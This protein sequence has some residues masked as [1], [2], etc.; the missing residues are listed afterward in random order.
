MLPVNASAPILVQYTNEGGIQN[1]LDILPSITEEAFFESNPEA[2]RA[3]AMHTMCFEGDAEG[4]M[5]L[6]RDASEEG[7]NVEDLIRFQDPLEDLKSALHYAVEGNHEAV[8]WLLLWLSSSLPTSDFPEP[9][10]D[11]AKAL[12][13]KRLSVGPEGDIR[14]LRDEHGLTAGDIAQRFG[15]MSHLL[16]AGYLH[17]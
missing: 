15:H 6:L 1:D 8:V 16:E 4:I 13:I 9:V 2:R 10:Q 11:Q 5:D 14:T 12:S 17:A 3:K 7:A